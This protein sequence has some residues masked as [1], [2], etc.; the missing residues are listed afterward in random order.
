MNVLNSATLK[1]SGINAIEAALKNGPVEILKHNQTRAIILSKQDF[2]RY[3]LKKPVAQTALKASS[4]GG[5]L[6]GKT[7][8]NETQM[9]ERLSVIKDGWEK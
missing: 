7:G 6:K 1:R 2:E 3:E 5:L 8:L 4:F 9:Q